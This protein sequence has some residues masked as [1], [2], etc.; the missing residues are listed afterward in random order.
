MGQAAFD[1]AGCAP[2]LSGCLPAPGRS[3]RE[4]KF[5]AVRIAVLVKQ[6]P[7]GETM[8]LLPSGRLNREGVELEMNAYCRRAVSKGVSLAGEHGGSCTV[9]TLGPPSAEDSLREAVAWGADEGVLVSDPA[10]A[11]SDTLATARALAAAIGSEGP[12]DLVIAGRN[13]IDADTGQVPPELAELLDLPFAAG[14]KELELSATTVTATCELDDGWRKVTVELPAVVSVAERLCEPAK[15]DTDR[16]AAV[17]AGRIRRLASSDLGAG[18][19]GEHGSP[20]SV[21][22]VRVMEVERRRVVLDGPVDEQVQEA[23]RLLGQWGALGAGANPPTALEGGVGPVPL[24]VGGGSSGGRV[25]AVVTEPGRTRLARELVGEA[26]QLASAIGGSVSV[27]TWE[28]SSDELSSWG[29]DRIV[30]LEGSTV[31]ED[32]AGALTGWCRAVSPWAV[33]SGGTLWGREVAGRCAAAIG[34]GLTGD[35]VG[36]GVTDGRL[37]AWK[38]AFGGRLVAAITASS[39]VQMATVRPGVLDVRDARPPRRDVP[40]EAVHVA[41]RGRVKVDETGRDDDVEAV[42]SAR[43]LVCVGAGVP[44]DAYD[45]LQ[46]L[47]KALG[48]E[49]AGTRKVTDKGWLPRARQIGITGHSVAPALY[50]ALGVQGKFNHVVGT[51]SAGTV[52]AVNSDPGAPVFEWADVGIVGDWSEV[53]PALVAELDSSRSDSG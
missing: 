7:R 5:L 20:T 53:V 38:P 39:P 6:V 13:S 16:R 35:A 10:L 34:A 47:L 9:F 15:V 21:G 31:E 28:W 49:L 46:P 3:L 48:A 22:Q 8:E 50:V 45:D 41:T 17:D 26:A 42:M 14:V 30:R 44:R 2:V 51:R 43:A 27:V 23:I 11:G 37:V 1:G 33:L 18:P 24:E 36:F 19:F 12:F 4:G 32:V 52:L 29:A 40:T 25:V